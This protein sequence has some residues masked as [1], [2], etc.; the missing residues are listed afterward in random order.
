MFTQSSFNHYV[1][2]LVTNVSSLLGSV[3][4]QKQTPIFAAKITHLSAVSECHVMGM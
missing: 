3:H 2:L 1:A 4:S